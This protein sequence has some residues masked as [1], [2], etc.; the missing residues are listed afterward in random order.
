MKKISLINVSQLILLLLTL[1]AGSLAEGRVYI[2]VTSPGGRKL[3]IAIQD[4]TGIA[5]GPGV[6]EI[7]KSDLQF[8]NLFSFVDKNAFLETSDT[9]FNADNWRPLGVDAVVKGVFE[10]SSDSSLSVTVSVYDVVEMRNILKKNYSTKKNLLRPLAHKIADDLYEAIT[11]Q[12]GVFS[13]R[14][15]FIGYDS[16]EGRSI[17]LMDFDGQRIKKIVKKNSL[18][19][20]PHWSPDSKRL[21]YSFLRK[22]RWAINIL[23]FDTAS[24]TEVFS[25]KGTNLVGD[26][27][28]DGK[29]LLLSS[30]SKGSP[31]IYLLQLN[32]RVLTP[33]TYADTIEVSPAS[34][35]DGGHI[36]YVSNKSGTP[37]LY[38]MNSDGSDS[39]RLTF[40]GNYNTAP[41]WSPAGDLIAF[42][43]MTGGRF[44]IATIKPDGTSLTVLT[45]VGNN[46][47]PSFS[48]DGRY[49]VFTSDRDGVKGVY[50][51]SVTAD[52]QHRI[53]PKNIRAFGPSWSHN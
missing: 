12:K 2:D 42:C 43:M 23:N 53:S 22:G 16:A 21:A 19:M 18:I 17:Y 35:P 40:E 20:R 5:E 29:D 6:S 27:T 11:G 33:L 8:T 7:I 51:M 1:C 25:S 15:A 45:N 50:V 38:I 24:E 30:S 14:I 36:V 48:A 46:E 3:P 37:Q 13:T 10:G 34:S 31:D 39:R 44:Q 26:F 4:F 28:P 41:E 49:I 32:S 47:E 9:P 52:E